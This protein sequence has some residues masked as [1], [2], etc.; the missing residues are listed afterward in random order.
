VPICVTYF[1]GA[2]TIDELEKML[3]TPKAP[4]GKIN[5]FLGEAIFVY[6]CIAI[7][8]YCIF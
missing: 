5:L 8:N 2:Y 6:V 4:A 1:G 3:S 7:H